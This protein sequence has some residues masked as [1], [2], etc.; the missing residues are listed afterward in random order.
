MRGP[1]LRYMILVASRLAFP[2]FPRVHVC[3]IVSVFCVYVPTYNP[4]GNYQPTNQPC[5]HA[6]VHVGVTFRGRRGA[7]SAI[8]RRPPL[9][10]LFVHDSTVTRRYNWPSTVTFSPSLSRSPPQFHQLSSRRRCSIW[11]MGNSCAKGPPREVDDDD[12]ASPGEKAGFRDRR[13]SVSQVPSDKGSPNRRLSVYNEDAEPPAEVL[14]DIP[15]IAVKSVAG[16]EPVPGGATRK[17]N[18]ARA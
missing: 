7:G 5:M 1:L 3:S 18:Q 12:N 9:S 16:M 14:A 8:T 17:I 2:R 10:C 11:R 6:Y 15:S 4:T 13:L